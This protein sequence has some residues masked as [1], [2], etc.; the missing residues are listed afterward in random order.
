[1][2]LHQIGKLIEITRDVVKLEDQAAKKKEIEINRSGKLFNIGVIELPTFY[3][4]FD[5]YRKNRYNY[6]IFKKFFS[7]LKVLNMFLPGITV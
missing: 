3:M 5:A 2:K 4:D 6:K 1:M 7:H